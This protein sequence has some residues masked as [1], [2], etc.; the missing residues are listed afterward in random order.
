MSSEFT[1]TGYHMPNEIH[2]LYTP[3]TNPSLQ[4]TA[5]HNIKLVPAPVYKPGP[6]EV[7]LH[8]K[9][10]GICGSDLHL[11]KKGAIGSLVV[12]GDCILGHEGAAQVLE[13]G[14]GV[15]HLKV[16]DRV[17]I[18]PGVPCGKCFL[19]VGGRYNLCEDVHFAG[20]YPYAGTLQRYKVHPAKW[21][22]K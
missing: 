10:T 2:P 5:D 4:V 6:G 8:V 22:H 13:L 20:V 21:L 19:C 14:P 18:E 9:A 7:L 12:E 11:W 16:G 17:A 1:Q 15:S 3:Q